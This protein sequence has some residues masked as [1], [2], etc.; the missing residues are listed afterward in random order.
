MAKLLI[1][2]GST[3]GNTEMVAEQVADQ[4]DAHNPVLQDIADTQPKD[5]SNY[6]AIIMGSSTWD[7]GLLQTDFRDFAENL[8]VDLSGKKIAVFGLGDSSYPDF[9]EAASLLEE[10]VAKNKGELLVEPLKIDG[11]PDEEENESKIRAWCDS[12][13]SKL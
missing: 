1:I 12:L 3:T 13:V 7:D 4:L 11:F 2:Y 8:N 6:D 5:L 9:C 10:L